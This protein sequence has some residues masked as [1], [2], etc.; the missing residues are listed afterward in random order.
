[1]LRVRDYTRLSVGTRFEGRDIVACDHCGKPALLDEVEG[2]KW[3]THSETL[4]FDNGG[5]PIMDWKSCPP[6]VPNKAP[7]A[8]PTG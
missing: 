5:N 1:M 4:G 6:I 2:K 7:G 8:S 3:F